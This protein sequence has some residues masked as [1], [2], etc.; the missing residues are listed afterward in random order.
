MVAGYSF[1]DSLLRLSAGLR[2]LAQNVTVPVRARESDD[3][4]SR[5]SEFLMLFSKRMGY[6][7]DVHRGRTLGEYRAR[8][9]HNIARQ[10][11]Q[12]KQQQH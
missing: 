4:R 11:G 10:Y 1:P 6:V 2:S 8:M 12:N 3:L 7:V 5:D 9:D